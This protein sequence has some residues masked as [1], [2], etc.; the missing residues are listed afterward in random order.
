M[1]GNVGR[2]IGRYLLFDEI[3]SGGMASVHLGRLLGP[4][5]FARTVAIKRL[6]PHL[7]RNPEFVA[8]FLDEARLAARIH[9]PNVVLTLDAVALDGEVFLVLEH[10]QGQSLAKLCR[11]A[12]VLKQHVPVGI[13][14]SVIT[15]L[16]T[17]LQAAHD[18]HGEQGEPLE[19][20][21]RDVSPQ[22]VLVG[23]DGVARV[24]DFGVA[25][26]A[27]R[28]HETTGQGLLKGKLAYMAPEQINGRPVDR[29]ADIFA[30][31][32]VAWEVLTG[33][34]LF[35]RDEPGATVSAV[36][37]GRI[38]EPSSI[39][40][41]LSPEID[42]IVLRGL[43]RDRG[44][45]FQ[46]AEDMATALEG[47]S[48]LA[49]PRAVGAWVRDLAA[50]AIAERA[51]QLAQIEGM[52][53]S[54]SGLSSPSAILSLPPEKPATNSPEDPSNSQQRSNVTDISFVAS[55]RSAW[56][57]PVVLTATGIALVLAGGGIWLATRPRPMPAAAAAIT[58]AAASAPL[59]AR[60]VPSESAAPTAA[61][62]PAAKAS[63]EPAA[64]ASTAPKASAPSKASTTEHAKR[65]APKH[66]H[67]RSA[68]AAVPAS[69]KPPWSIDSSGGKRF[70]PQCVRYL[71]CL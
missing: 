51:S 35:A 63:A 67:P 46:T 16:L 59:S 71:K 9:H 54:H 5:G 10:V 45:R 11:A 12:A 4:V 2:N 55:P 15:G 20:V 64:D 33:R 44:N 47:V 50:D 22:N 1:D 7:A 40:A 23:V 25:K 6:H 34:R 57:S 21:H 56:R 28:L 17:G 62:E 31:S 69:C 48:R 53:P 24:L 29:R 14:L 52:T 8:M 30:A 42:A 60:P 32:V 37:K 70:K 66:V 18:A 68:C 65:A 58:S 36:L 39:R 38:P 26:A 61:T 41:S 13:A 3:A 43:E 49:T 27:N 19:I